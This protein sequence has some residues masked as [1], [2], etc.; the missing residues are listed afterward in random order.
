MAYKS[1]LKS[2]EYFDHTAFVYH[3]RS[4]GLIYDF[5]SLI[6]Q[7]RNNIVKKFLPSVEN[8]EKILDFGMGP[9]VFAK[10]CME[11]GY[12]YLG[13][14]ISPKMVERAKLLKLE[15]A[16][17]RVGDVDS[18]TK[19]K[20][21]MD[22]ALAIGL[23]DYVEDPIKVIKLLNNCLKED[24]HLIISFRNRYSF[25]RFFRDT[26]KLIWKKILKNKV[27]K[28]NKAFFSNVNEHSFDF[29]TQL[30][31][32]LRSV[33]FNSFTI[34]YFNCSPFFFNF[35]IKPSIWHKWYKLDSQLSREWMRFLC[36]GFVVLA[37]KVSQK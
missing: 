24:G 33:G 19:Y 14:D 26:I 8:K 25:P 6:F 12:Y 28:S 18:L 1:H 4:D 34:K 37:N 29:S 13:I 15:N 3:Q 30:L 36:S 22:Y 2:K 23:I 35:P 20:G 11:N 7:R 27:T 21:E 5:S 9:G 17:F 31:P 32:I 10:Y 16:K